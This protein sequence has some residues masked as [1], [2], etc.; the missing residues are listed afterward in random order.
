VH[1]QNAVQAVNES[2]NLFLTNIHRLYRV[3]DSP[4]FTEADN[5]LD[6]FF[7]PK[8]TP[9]TLDDRVDLTTVLRALPDL[10]ILNDEAH[11]IHDEQ[12]T[13]FQTIQDLVSQFRL[14]GQAVSAQID[15]TATPKHA[16]GAIF[17]QTVSDYPLVEA[18]RQGIVKRPV[19]PDQASRAKL[20]IR[21]STDYAE[22]YADYLHLGYLEWEKVRDALA[23]TGKKPILFIMTDDTK[24]CDAVQDYL[25]RPYPNL[26]P[27]LVIHTKRNGE[28]AEGNTN[29]NKAELE[30]LRDLANTID[31]HAN[32]YQAIVSVMVLREGWDVQNVV[33]IVGLRPFQSRSQILPEQALGRGLRRMFRGAAVPEQV[34]VIGTDAFMDFV[35]RIK[36]DGVDLDYQP[37]GPQTPPKGPMT[38]QVDHG[39]P[40]KN[41]EQLDITLPE[42]ALRVYREYKNSGELDM[43]AVDH[44]HWPV[45]QFSEQA[46]REIVFRDIDTEG[47]DHAT[48]L[49][50]A[51]D[52]NPNQVVGYFARTIMRDLR[53]VG[54]FD[55]LFG[56]LK[57]FLQ[58]DL[59]TER[60]R[61]DDLNILRNLSELEVT[62]SI[63][64]TVKR[65][66]NALT[67]RDKGTTRVQNTITLSQKR[68]FL[69]KD[70]AFFVP[71]KSV[72]NKIVGDSGFEL[73]F[74]AFLDVCDDL[75]AFAKN[76]QNQGFAIEY[77]KATGG[78]A[79][80]YPDWF[81]K[82]TET[83]LWII[84]TKGREDVDDP[85]KWQR[86]VQWS[87]DA[88]T[89]E[90]QRTF[91]ALYVAQERWEQ[92]RPKTF[93]ELCRLFADQRPVESAP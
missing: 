27:I 93:Q 34:S 37:M 44:R 32:P 86:L 55:D 33:T 30:K 26:R 68:P 29:Q 16:N 21:Q 52:P 70:Q 12:L 46:Q 9:K 58:D 67:I 47:I 57:R 51:L 23:P 28:L 31:D 90:G 74:A 15:V 91:Q 53:L 65:A 73:E 3:A 18:I 25:D 71:K 45:R 87:Q 42:L 41:L 10:L 75:I 72:F 50:L 62:A 78:I 24:D 43:A 19:L 54:G 35:E 79:K 66:I 8:P 49:D 82:E 20:H 76:D 22:Q 6:Y 69:V 88:T 84:E 81:V 89:E 61:L 7:G 80:Y 56:K 59:F 92:Y 39:H 38:I 48:V 1:L 77:H 17:V 5:T 11:H 36:A 85:H 83:H 63:F 2:G 60:V 4:K 14:K 64:D 40:K 13:W